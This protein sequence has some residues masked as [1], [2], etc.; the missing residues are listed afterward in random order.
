MTI[1]LKVTGMSC[2]H[3]VRAVTQALAAVPGVSGASVT[4]E[5][6]IAVVEGQGPPEPLIQAV[7]DAGYQA[8]LMAPG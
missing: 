4:L 8:E 6:G 3:C 1:E 7:V 5:T 2:Q